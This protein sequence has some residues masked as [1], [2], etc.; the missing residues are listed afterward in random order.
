MIV[1]RPARWCRRPSIAPA[2]W[3]SAAT[4]PVASIAASGASVSPSAAGKSHQ[5]RAR[6]RARRSPPSR[7]WCGPRCGRRATARLRRGV[8]QEDGAARPPIRAAAG[9]Q[10]RLSRTLA[11]SRHAAWQRPGEQLP[12]IAGPAGI[13]VPRHRR[14]SAEGWQPGLLGEAAV[15]GLRP[16]WLRWAHSCCR[17][18]WRGSPCPAPE[19]RFFHTSSPA[20][21]RGLD[22]GMDSA[23][24]YAGQLMP[25][26]RIR[27][28]RSPLGQ[29][30]NCTV[31]SHQSCPAAVTVERFESTIRLAGHP[32]IASTFKSP[33]LWSRTAF[34]TEAPPR[35]QPL[36]AISPSRTFDT[37]FSCALKPLIMGEPAGMA[38]KLGI[39]GGGDVAHRGALEEI[40]HR[41]RPVGARP[42]AGRQHAVRAE[43]TKLPMVTG[44]CGPINISAALVMRPRCTN[45]SVDRSSRCS[46]A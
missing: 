41:E 4:L 31:P 11:L 32:A 28:P 42:A 33:L 35:Y 15:A 7:G 24:Y 16:A 38:G 46:G 37:A 1:G 18:A 34:I 30:G 43:L 2:N 27:L 36:R 39:G 12:T 22:R 44:V 26:D 20:L 5:G 10:H 29:Y 25:G 9:H 19:A 17:P 6:R 23:A 3:P 40:R 8:R 13:D 21:T 45:G 14:P